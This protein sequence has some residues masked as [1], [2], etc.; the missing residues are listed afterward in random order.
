[1]RV[2]NFRKLLRDLMVIENKM[3]PMVLDLTPSINDRANIKQ[4][5]EGQMTP[6]DAGEFRVEQKFESEKR[7]FAF[8]VIVDVPKLSS[9]CVFRLQNPSIHFASLKRLQR[10]D[11]A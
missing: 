7:I 10:P 3:Q 6:S 9:K 11:L 2:D 5:L 1:M 4:T 8:C